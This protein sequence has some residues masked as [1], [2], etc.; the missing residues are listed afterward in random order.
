M[1]GDSRNKGE[2]ESIE[3]PFEQTILLYKNRSV[4]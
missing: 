2:D 3:D 1:F 4:S